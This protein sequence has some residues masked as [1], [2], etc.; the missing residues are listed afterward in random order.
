[1]QNII[2]L[3]A[4]RK[5]AYE[6]VEISKDE[7]IGIPTWLLSMR[8]RKTAAKGGHTGNRNPCEAANPL[9]VR[10]TGLGRGI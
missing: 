6:L 2:E 8:W 5:G 3:N 10:R 4:S 7:H 1:M 9:S